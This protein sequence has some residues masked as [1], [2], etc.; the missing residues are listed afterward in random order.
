MLDRCAN[1]ATRE[2]VFFLATNTLIVFGL[3][4]FDN[5]LAILEAFPTLFPQVPPL[6]SPLLLVQALLLPTS[7][8]EDGRIEGLRQGLARLRKKSRSFYLASAFFQGRLRIDLI[9]LYSFCRVA[10][11]LVDDA[12]STHEAKKWI[13][14]LVE[15]LDLSYGTDESSKSFRKETFI[16]NT[17]P[18]AA[19]SA[20]LLLPTAY[21]PSTPLYDLLKGFETDLYFSSPNNPFPI[22]D[23]ETLRVYASH[24]AGTVAELFL[25]LVFYHMRQKMSH[26]QRES[27]TRAG[28]R[29][30]IALQYV[31]IARDISV[32]AGICRVYLPADW[33][34]SKNLKPEDVVRNSTN[35]QVETLRQ[36]LLD[37][38]MAI[39]EV[40]R[41][42]ID[43]L[44]TESR[45]PLRVAVESYV[46]IGRVLREPSYSVKSGRATVPKVR[47]LRV[48]WNA[49]QKG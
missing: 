24:V 2:A 4:A 15:F 16:R 29:M 41:N 12:S 28:G 9:M 18:E 23:E 6:P 45:G 35:R 26:S 25:E 1:Q 3:V 38:A 27:I 22:S 33:L 19:Q 20:L 49:L 21:L 43:Q 40:N 8:Y 10:D 39:Y 14:K 32:D 44:P 37:K 31:N 7:K 42:A 46:E 48:A 30:G 17:F 13:D 36:Q 5:A 47:R 11:D 34:R